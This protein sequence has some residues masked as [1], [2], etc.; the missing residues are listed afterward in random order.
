MEQMD[1]VV[2]AVEVGIAEL[3]VYTYI[4]ETAAQA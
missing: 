3:A 1:L 4:V 2:V